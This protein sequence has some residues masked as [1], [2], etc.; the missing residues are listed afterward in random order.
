LAKANGNEFYLVI[1]Y[2]YA[3]FK[4]LLNLG[5]FCIFGVLA[6]SGKT[7]AT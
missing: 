6:K 3:I 7:I 2:F 1:K 4:Q 5:G